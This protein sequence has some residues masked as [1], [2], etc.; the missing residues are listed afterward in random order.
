MNKRRIFIGAAMSSVLLLSACGN[1][2]NLAT[3]KSG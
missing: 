3:S 2:D 1:S